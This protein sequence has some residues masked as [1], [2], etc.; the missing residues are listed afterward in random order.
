MCDTYDV[1]VLAAH[2]LSGARVVAADTDRGQARALE[3]D[4]TTDAVQVKT[5]ETEEGRDRGLVSLQ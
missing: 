4:L 3:A 1:V 2:R 5:Q